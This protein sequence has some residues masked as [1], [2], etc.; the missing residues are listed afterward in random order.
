M[1]FRDGFTV[2][3]IGQQ[4]LKNEF[5]KVELGDYRLTCRLEH[6]AALLG[7]DFQSNLPSACV[8]WKEIKAA[9]RFFSNNHVNSENI[10]TTHFENTIARVD[11]LE[12][13]PILLVQDTTSFNYQSHRA[14]AFPLQRRKS[15]YKVR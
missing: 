5:N 2:K 6:L 9:Y 13:E 3:A 10:Q 15:S 11:D 14:I 4:P 1:Q 12:A 7:N 8:D